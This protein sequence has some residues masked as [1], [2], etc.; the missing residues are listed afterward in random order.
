[1]KIKSAGSSLSGEVLDALPGADNCDA[2][3]K[4]QMPV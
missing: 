1:M 3:V 2:G 4:Y